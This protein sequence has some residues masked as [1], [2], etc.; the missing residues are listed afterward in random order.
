MAAKNVTASKPISRRA[1]TRPDVSAQIPSNRVLNEKF[2]LTFGDNTTP[3]T[4]QKMLCVAIDDIRR[5]GPASFNALKLCDVL[6]VSYSLLN[7]HFGSRDEL[8]AEALV[9]VY[10]DVVRET[11]QTVSGAPRNPRD[12]LRAWVEGTTKAF[13]HAGGWGV[14]INY[15]L[16]SREVTELIRF[17]YGQEMFDLAELNLARLMQLVSD[18]Q[19]DNVTEMSPERGELPEGLFVSDLGLVALARSV[20]L[21]ASGLAVWRGGRDSAEAERGATPLDEIVEKLHIDR[22]IAST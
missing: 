21:S 22:I 7:F 4:R 12:R 6:D 14:L 10:G 19:K 16:A 17:R 5:V 15:P 11:W 1:K 3:S 18:V 13:T 2:W 20:A 9:I 8:L